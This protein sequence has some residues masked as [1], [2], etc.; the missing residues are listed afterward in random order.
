MALASKKKSPSGCVC[1]EPLTC[2]EFRFEIF[3][4]STQHSIDLPS[5]SKLTGTE[6]HNASR[7]VRFS[8]CHST[9]FYNF[10]GLLFADRIFVKPIFP[11][12]NND[13]KRCQSGRLGT[14]TLVASRTLMST[15]PGWMAK[16]RNIDH[17]TTGIISQAATRT[18]IMNDY[19]EDRTISTCFLI[20]MRS[21][22]SDP[23]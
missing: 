12:T 3:Q 15:L 9:C 2:T 23:A 19:Y 20:T 11:F 22:A 21:W 17:P 6:L 16:W 14:E 5:V 10:I 18:I 8:I 13:N 1:V 7:F 4:Y